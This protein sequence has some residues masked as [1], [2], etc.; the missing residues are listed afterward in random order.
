VPHAIIV[1]PTRQP[2]QQHETIN[3]A[4]DELPQGERQQIIENTYQLKPADDEKFKAADVRRMMAALLD[5]R[6]K[7]KKYDA[8]QCNQ[9]SK[10]LCTDIKARVK[11]KTRLHRFAR[12]LRHNCP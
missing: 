11:G 9:L 4:D 8:A 5:E 7:G 1:T 3:M 2:L 10:D 6:L 12:I